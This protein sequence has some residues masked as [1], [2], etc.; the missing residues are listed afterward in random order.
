MNVLH[1]HLESVEASGFGNLNLCAE[2][3]SEIFEHNAV[4]SSEEAEHVLDVMLLVLSEFLPVFDVLAEIDL[5]NS[6]EAGHLVFVHLPD[7]F[8]L[9]R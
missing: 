3:L 8:V 2:S 1:H 4:R 6:P 5:V 9:D 7:V